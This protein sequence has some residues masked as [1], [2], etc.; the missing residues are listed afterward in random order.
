MRDVVESEDQTE[1][2]SVAEDSDAGQDVTTG[3]L[4]QGDA[5]HRNLHR[6][7][8]RVG[9]AADDVTAVNT[10]PCLEY[11]KV[12]VVDAC[13]VSRQIQQQIRQQI[14]SSRGDETIPSCALT[15][16]ARTMHDAVMVG[17]ASTSS[18]SG[19]VGD[20]GTPPRVRVIR[21]SFYY[22]AAA[23]GK[24]PTHLRWI[25]SSPPEEHDKDLPTCD[26][27]TDIGDASQHPEGAPTDV[28]QEVQLSWRDC[29]VVVED[30][31]SEPWVTFR[32]AGDV[33]AWR[34]R[35]IHGAREEADRDYAYVIFDGKQQSAKLEIASP[36]LGLTGVLLTNLFVGN[37]ID[38]GRLLNG[39]WPSEV[40][41]LA[42]ISADQVW[43]HASPWLDAMRTLDDPGESTALREAMRLATRVRRLALPE[44]RRVQASLDD[45]RSAVQADQDLLQATGD[46]RRTLMPFAFEVERTELF[47]RATEMYT[48]EMH[49]AS[50]ARPHATRRR[51][52]TPRPP[53]GGR[54]G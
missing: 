17:E 30:G 32:R 48:E 49:K 24:P 43:L 44:A 13:L 41:Q 8:R 20:L 47:Q 6:R 4:A 54:R 1:I 25:E 14:R 28:R 46:L 37:E 21:H 18:T 36:G 5:L 51:S 35:R 3:E 29:S 16:R 42:Q 33:D 11:L 12:I 2:V 31:I 53:T 34:H 22:R 27:T 15:S 45:V 52:P 50:A 19:Q 39:M 7:V 23:E 9:H 38:V 10:R 40:V 26:C